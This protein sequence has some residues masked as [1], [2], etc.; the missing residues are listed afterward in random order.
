MWLDSMLLLNVQK[1]DSAESIK[2]LY[3]MTELAIIIAGKGYE[4]CMS[5]F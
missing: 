5:A 2:A 4:G 1:T 3:F